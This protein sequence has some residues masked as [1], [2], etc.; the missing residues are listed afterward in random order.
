M[1]VRMKTTYAGPLG[2]CV[3]G[4]E[5]DVSAEQAALLVHGHYAEYVIGA[6]GVSVAPDAEPVVVDVPEVEPDPVAAARKPALDAKP[7]RG[8]PP[9]KGRRGGLDT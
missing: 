4:D 5:L 6:D 1:K 3:A 2:T 7:R 8:R 9:G